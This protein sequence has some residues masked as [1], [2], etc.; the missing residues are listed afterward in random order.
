M[1]LLV[2]Y[3]LNIRC[4]L[5]VISTH[6][7]VYICGGVISMINHIFKFCM[8]LYVYTFSFLIKNK[9][10]GFAYN[11][12]IKLKRHSK[13]KNLKSICAPISHFQPFRASTEK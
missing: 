8:F 13:I 1:Y 10:V 4:P 9:R 11:C 3:T 12:C 6:T 7:Y 5:I 2:L